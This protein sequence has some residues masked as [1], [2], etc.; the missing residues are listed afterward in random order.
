MTPRFGRWLHVL[1]PGCIWS[2][3]GSSVCLTF[4]D[5]PHPTATPAVLRV[6]DRY[7]VKASFFLLGRSVH[8]HPDLAREIAGRGHDVGVH[9]YRHSRFM[10]FSQR[11]TID[12]IR[13]TE[14]VLLDAGVKARKIFRPPYGVVTWNTIRAARATG[15]RLFLWSYLTGDFR[16]GAEDRFLM[17]LRPNLRPG[18]IL[19]YHDNDLTA[20]RIERLLS[21]SIEEILANGLAIQPLP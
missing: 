3:P 9:G 17:R 10:A 2:L 20:G 8:D 5:G 12:E 19:V 1:F 14:T 6:L 16:N 11:R 13:R 4:D 7:A 15:Y 18:A 21:R